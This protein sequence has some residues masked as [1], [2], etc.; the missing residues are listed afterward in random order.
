MSRYIKSEF[1]RLFRCKS[2]YLFIGICSLLLLSANILL[3]VVKF[4]DKSF[5]WASTG[6]SFSFIYTSMPMILLLCIVVSHLIF[7][8]EHNNHT[9][10]NSVSYGISRGT[11]YFGKLL[12]QMVY[13][14]T[15]FVIIIGSHI[16]SGY[17][18]LEN[19]GPK[20]LELLLLT[21]LVCLPL[22]LFGLAVT[23]C[24]LFIIESIGG[25]IGAAVGV[26]VA[27][28]LVSGLLGMRFQFFHNLSIALPWNMI[29]NM[30]FDREN[31]KILFYWAEGFR[32]YWILGI[33]Q[34][35]LFAVLGF[36]LFRK[37]EIK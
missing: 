33:S 25:A 32:N 35:L 12:V 37:K 24:F 21:C 14:I 36:W 18:L 28:P 34:M 4:A 9:M 29:N 17:L 27:I 16:L 20:E 10:K 22:F 31:Y 11:I 8:N 5:P 15:A 23:N 1:Y 6:F 19:S 26:M 7:G 13:A 2:S 3:A 30:E